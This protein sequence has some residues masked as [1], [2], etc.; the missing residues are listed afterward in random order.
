MRLQ[1]FKRGTS[2]F[3]KG[4]KKIAQKDKM[5]AHGLVSKHSMQISDKIT[6]LA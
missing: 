2:S 6:H 4:C 1:G 3:Q 5:G